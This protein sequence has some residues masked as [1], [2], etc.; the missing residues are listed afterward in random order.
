MRY[1]FTISHV[2]G[3]DLAIADAL[4]RALV[5]EPTADDLLL[6]KSTN[7]FIDFTMEYRPKSE[8]G[9]Q[10]IR[11]QQEVDAVIKQV[12]RYYLDGWP[13]KK[14]LSGPVRAYSQVSA[15]LTVVKG[16]LMRGARIVISESMRPEMLKNIHGGHRG[17]S[18]CRERAHQSVCMV[19]R[20]VKTY[21]RASA[22]MPNML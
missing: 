7:A 9:I 14:K 5:S 1:S 22:A 17:I 21:K 6:Q 20:I 18:K 13:E 2:A 4:S 8:K 15:E 3:K 16:L 10:Q 19:A 11:R 12:A